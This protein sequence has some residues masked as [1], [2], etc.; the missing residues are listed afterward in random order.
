MNLV[1]IPARIAWFCIN[2]S[3][4]VNNG[5]LCACGATNLFPLAKWLSASDANLAPTRERTLDPQS[6]PCTSQPLET[7]L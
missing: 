7:I 3:S 6:S 1:T 5:N 2:C 4:I